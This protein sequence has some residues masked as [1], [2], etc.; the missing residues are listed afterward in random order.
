M[1]RSFF[2]VILALALCSA[3]VAQQA[4]QVVTSAGPVTYLA[5]GQAVMASSTPVVIASDQTAVAVASGVAPGTAIIGVGTGTTGAV[6]GTLAAAASKTTYI[7]G[8]SVSATGGVATLGPIVIAGLSGG[9]FTYQLF[10]TATGANLSQSFAP[11]LPSSAVNTAITVTTTADGTA[12][13]V[14]VN[15]S[16]FQK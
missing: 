2:A 1:K 4:V 7:C 13:A 10:S 11:C 14:D 15:A 8:F 9:S 5:A 6:V 3:A 16:G 12:T